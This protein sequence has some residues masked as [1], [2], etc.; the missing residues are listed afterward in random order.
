MVYSL[1]PIVVTR[2]IT[3][4][5]TMEGYKVHGKKSH[6]NGIPYESPLDAGKNPIIT[7]MAYGSTY[8]QAEQ[9]HINMC[10]KEALIGDVQAE[11]VGKRWRLVWREKSIASDKCVGGIGPAGENHPNAICTDT[12]VRRLRQMQKNGMTIKSIAETSRVSIHQVKRIL[13][14]ESWGHI[15]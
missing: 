7:I 5:I 8:K 3:G 2:Q 12:E 6:P 15:K 9:R 4:G 14:G 11:R 10:N 13:K 1:F